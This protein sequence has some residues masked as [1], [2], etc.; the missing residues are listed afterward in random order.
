MWNL[1]QA[2]P[3][4]IISMLNIWL[5]SYTF[6]AGGDR[7]GFRQSRCIVQSKRQRNYRTTLDN[8]TRDPTDFDNTLC[9]I[10]LSRDVSASYL[11]DSE[12]WCPTIALYSRSWS[13]S[14]SSRLC[15]CDKLAVYRA[16]LCPSDVDG[17]LRYCIDNRLGRLPPWLFP[18]RCW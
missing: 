2:T 5:K 16:P 6:L 14:N 3:L 13:V 1:L 4:W 7:A 9:N 10:R 11:Y 17:G 12:S 18:S 8:R 15:R